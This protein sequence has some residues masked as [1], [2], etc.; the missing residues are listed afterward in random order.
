M[1]QEIIPGEIVSKTFIDT[2]VY[3]GGTGTLLGFVIALFIFSKNSNSKKLSKLAAAPA[4]FNISELAMFGFPV[5][6]NPFMILP[7]ILVPEICYSLTF[8]VTKAGFL[9][10]VTNEVNWTV[11]LFLSGFIAT[12]SV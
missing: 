4:I 5:I 3:M 11:P 10:L 2:F 1:F 6:C 12:A 7:F 8:L 9:P